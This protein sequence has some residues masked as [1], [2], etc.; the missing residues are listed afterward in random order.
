[1]WYTTYSESERNQTQMIG[2]GT[3]KRMTYKTLMK[4][5]EDGYA[6][7]WSWATEE[8]YGESVADVVFY[9][10]NGNFTRMMVEVTQIPE[11]SKR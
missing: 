2:E 7:V 1:M 6:E 5:I 3:M 8:R 10:S 9:R 4:K 11:G